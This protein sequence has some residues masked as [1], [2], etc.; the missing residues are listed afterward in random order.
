MQPSH[1]S[2]G[3]P[4]MGVVGMEVA[5][6]RAVAHLKAMEEAGKVMDK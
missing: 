1:T 6:S 5:S 2:L 3:Q 4:H